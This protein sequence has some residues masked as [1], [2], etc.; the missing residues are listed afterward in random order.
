MKWNELVT[1]SEFMAKWMQ[2]Y[3]G[4]DD[5]DGDTYYTVAIYVSRNTP[6]R[7]CRQSC[8]AWEVWEIN[9]KTAWRET[10]AIMAD[11]KDI[12]TKF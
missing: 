10:L 12:F 3:R 5:T 6:Y 9:P 11:G 7:F 1:T 4:C 8:G 2:V